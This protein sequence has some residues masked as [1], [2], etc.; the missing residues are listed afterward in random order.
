MFPV[1]S[2]SWTDSGWS[3]ATTQARHS[4]VTV[5]IDVAFSSEAPNLL[6]YA[7]SLRINIADAPAAAT[8][9]ASPTFG[10]VPPSYPNKHVPAN[11]IA[12]ESHVSAS[13]LAP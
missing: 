5:T 8:H 7:P 13:I 12:A 6:V 2:R 11:A 4:A 10:G 3:V 9:H 1:N